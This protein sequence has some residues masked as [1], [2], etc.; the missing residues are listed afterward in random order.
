ME[1]HLQKAD[2]VQLC[3]RSI[4][5]LM[6]ISASMEA[7]T[8]RD[9]LVSLGGGGNGVAGTRGREKV[10]LWRGVLCPAVNSRASRGQRVA[11]SGNFKEHGMI[12]ARRAT[13]ACGVARNRLKKQQFNRNRGDDIDFKQHKNL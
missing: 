6:E 4:L 10:W 7:T 2:R 1:E 13:T 12:F 8:I 3:V 9:S 11:L 5:G